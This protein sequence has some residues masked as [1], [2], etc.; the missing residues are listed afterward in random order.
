M[1]NI[2]KRANHPYTT[3]A[4]S[5]ARWRMLVTVLPNGSV[6]HIGE[7]LSTVD[8]AM[9][10]L[11]LTEVLVGVGVL[12]LLGVTAAA[13]VRVGLRPLDDIETTAQAIA[14]GDLTRRVPDWSPG[15]STRTP[16]WGGWGG[17]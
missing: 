7:S 2:R 10:K 15:S 6:L 12:M 5:G 14:A 13:M 9:G 8:K 3:V 16:R 17:R 11:V 4:P 1:A